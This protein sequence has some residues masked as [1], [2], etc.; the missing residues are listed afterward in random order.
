MTNTFACVR[1][2]VEV[3]VRVRV[4]L[5]VYA[6]AF[7]FCVDVVLV[8]FEEGRILGRCRCSNKKKRTERTDREK[9]YSFSRLRSR[10]RRSRFL[11]ASARFSGPL[12]RA[13]SP[14]NAH[15]WRGREG[16]DVSRSRAKLVLCLGSQ[17]LNFHFRARTRFGRLLFGKNIW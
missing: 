14:V 17:I 3:R 11:D 7:V 16:G 6:F 9:S 12:S 1:M 2:C 5:Y 4:V 15:A 10:R 8:R 13:R